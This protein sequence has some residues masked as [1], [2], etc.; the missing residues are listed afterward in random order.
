MGW[1]ASAF[2]H[3]R[4]DHVSGSTTAYAY[5]MQ[6][7]RLGHS[8]LLVEDDNARLLIDPGTYSHGFDVFHLIFVRAINQ[9][10]IDVW[11]CW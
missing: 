4:Q 1:R 2:V 11:G 8:C 3:I 9:F 10:L 5:P 6:I 7:T